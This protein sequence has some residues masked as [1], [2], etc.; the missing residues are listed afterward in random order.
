LS[1]QKLS[2]QKGSPSAEMGVSGKVVEDKGV[3]EVDWY[4]QSEE[5]PIEVRASRSRE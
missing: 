3:G 1:W 4:V 5:V 2:V